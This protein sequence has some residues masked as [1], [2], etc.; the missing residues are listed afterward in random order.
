MT[1]QSF[2]LAVTLEVRQL[3]DGRWTGREGL[4]VR[5]QV[6]LPALGFLEIA[7]LLGQFHE[8]AERIKAQHAGD[9]S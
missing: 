6:E 9:P 1:G 4:Q 3:E 8:L 2:Q 5:E 7:A